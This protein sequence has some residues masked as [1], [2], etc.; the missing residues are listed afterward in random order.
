MGLPE[1][2]GILVVVV[3]SVGTKV[4]ICHNRIL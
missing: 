3:R 2:N 4:K 1:T